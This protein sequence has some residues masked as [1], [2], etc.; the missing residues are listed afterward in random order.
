M[1][2]HEV[3]L[4]INLG[5]LKVLQD[6]YKYLSD[7]QMLPTAYDIGGAAEGIF[8]LQETYGI[9]A[10]NFS[11]GTFDGMETGIEMSGRDCF[12]LGYQAYNGKNYERS[13]E[14][15]EESYQRSKIENKTINWVGLL[16]ALSTS[17]FQIGDIE[18]ALNISR[19]L[20]IIAPENEKAKMDTY[21]YESILYPEKNVLGYELTD[22]KGGEIQSDPFI[23]DE[24]EFLRYLKVCRGELQQS[25]TDKSKLKCYYK[26]DTHPSLK[27]GPVKVEDINLD[28]HV[29]IFHDVLF[30][31]EITQMINTSK[32]EIHRSQVVG[33]SYGQGMVG[34]YRVSQSTGISANQHSFLEKLDN[35]IEAITALSTISSEGHQVANYGIGGHYEPHLDFTSKYGD[36]PLEF[37]E[38]DGNRIATLVFYVSF[39]KEFLKQE[40][41]F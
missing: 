35:R 16:D 5:P 8:R 31:S 14:W 36:T 17:Y 12:D 34:E 37:W 10:K 30:D 1:E 2:W 29:V 28:P 21:K 24:H 38:Q 32:T 19:E 26:H 6:N 11:K 33:E 39:K 7:N 25:L 41:I 20:E 23:Y 27:I 40:H 22:E 15:L 9:D 13:S 4:S 3:D 18:K